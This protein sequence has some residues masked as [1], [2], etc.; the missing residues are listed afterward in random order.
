MRGKFFWEVF[1]GE[2][3]HSSALGLRTAPLW[4]VVLEI[5][6]FY[7]HCSNRNREVNRTSGHDL[8]PTACVSPTIRFLKPI[9]VLAS[10]FVRF[11]S[12]FCRPVSSSPWSPLFHYPGNTRWSRS[13]EEVVVGQVREYL[14]LA[15]ALNLPHLQT[16]INLSNSQ[17]R[18]LTPKDGNSMFLRNAGIYVLVYAAPKPKRTT[19][20]MSK[21]FS[22]NWFLAFWKVTWMPSV[23]CG[24]Q[25]H[26]SFLCSSRLGCDS[27]QR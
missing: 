20:S 16:L 7:W 12:E 22:I 15:P 5:S 6:T 25:M 8:E 27:K 18:H 1:V 23:R 17:H 11:R 26:F 14:R 10:E 13:G 4:P 9:T 3:V 21:I 2:K 19:L 24:L